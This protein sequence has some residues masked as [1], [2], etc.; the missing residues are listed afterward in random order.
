V[1]EDGVSWTKPALDIVPGTNIVLGLP[2][3]SSTVWLDFHDANPARRFKMAQFIGGSSGPLRWFDSRD[4]MH[5]RLTA[6][7]SPTGDRSTFFYNPFRRQWVYSLRAN[8]ASVRFRAYWETRRFDPVADW[9]PFGAIPW[10]SADR[11]DSV[12]ELRVRPQLYNLDCVAYESVLL[13]LF[14]IWQGDPGDRPKLNNVFVGFS[15]DGFHWTRG[16]S[17]PLLG[18]SD[19]RGAWNFGNVQSAG[20]CCLIV[21]DSLRFYVSG[22]AGLKGSPDSGACSTGLATLRRDGFA[23]M[24]RQD[25]D[26]PG[27]RNSGATPGRLTTRTIEF[28]GEHLFVNA[29]VPA[30]ELRVEVLT[31][32][33]GTLAPFTRE[34]CV[35]VRG[36]T[37]GSRVEWTR[38]TTLA[39]VRRRPVRLRFHLTA[40]HLYS[41]WISQSASGS[42]G[43][44]VA[45]GGPRYKGPIDS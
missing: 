9:G 17:R 44:Y 42:S 41:F 5:W 6:Q 14:T 13:G 37:T 18:V 4:G 25:W 35:P 2:R 1:S 3:D 33:G 31:A 40:G 10:V 45:A 12:G 34:A 39:P 7:S 27:S 30:G 24:T 36:D 19:R 8:V 43:G 29:D 22:R 20:G 15:R 16:A 32:D 38:A 28:S 11:W 23:S 21:D 26:W